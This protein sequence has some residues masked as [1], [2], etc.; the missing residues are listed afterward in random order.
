MKKLILLAV[1]LVLL[2]A[3]C[4]KKQ[5]TDILT[6][7][8]ATTNSTIV[9]T[10]ANANSGTSTNVSWQFNGSSW[11]PSGQPPA[12]P[13][14][15]V[16]QTPVDIG[17][18]TAILYPG[19]TRGG[20]YKAHGGFRFTAIANN[21]MTVVAPLAAQVVE[22]SRYIEGGEVQYLFTFINACG[23]MYR[24]DHLLTLSPALQ[25][26]ADQFPAAKVDD[27]RTTRVEPPVPVQAGDTLATAIGF[28]TTDNVFVDFGLYDLRQ[29]NAKAGEAAWAASHS[30][31]LAQ[32]GVCWF[33]YLTTA[34]EQTVRSLPA[35]DSTSGK[36]SDYC[37]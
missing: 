21:A 9:N 8:Q 2:G 4:D 28:K 22:G 36:T 30:V 37:L 27:S 18:A 12:C 24:L 1:P 6:A 25:A 17:Q 26:I 32:Y 15:L 31:Q 33:D 7:N 20:D 19:Q 23:L 34:D 14:P 5:A 16:L 29:K 3:S 10:A 35:G 13:D 11:Q